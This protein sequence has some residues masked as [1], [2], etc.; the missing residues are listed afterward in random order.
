MPRERREH[1]PVYHIYHLINAN[2]NTMDFKLWP[3]QTAER[4]LL[5]H[6]EL[7]LSINTKVI[8]RN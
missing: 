7:G 5:F 1:I 6:L 3:C 2:P 8:F 4:K